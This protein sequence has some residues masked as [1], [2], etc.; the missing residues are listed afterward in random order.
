MGQRTKPN[1]NTTKMKTYI[2][3]SLTTL[4]IKSEGMLCTSL[5][6]SDAE[7]DVSAK[8]VNRGGWDCSNWMP[9][10]ETAEDNNSKK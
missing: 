7:Y 6:V 10:E 8:S 9:A 3:P 2:A 5:R 1:N 4:E